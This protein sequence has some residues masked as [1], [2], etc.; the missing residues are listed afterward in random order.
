[1]DFNTVSKEAAVPLL[2]PGWGECPEVTAPASLCQLGYQ[3][4]QDGVLKP[5]PWLFSSLFPP[6]PTTRGQASVLIESKRGHS[7]WNPDLLQNLKSSDF[8]GGAV[9]KNP[10]AKA[11]DTRDMGSIP[12]WGRSPGGGNGNPLQHSCLENSMDRG[13]WRATVHG[14]AK[15]LNRTSACMC[16]HAHIHTHTLE[17]SDLAAFQLPYRSSSI[18]EE[19][20]LSPRPLHHWAAWQVGR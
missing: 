7:I 2:A 18:T 5:S 6:L 20:L 1:M 12:G 13:A 11:G 19:S 8:L 15:E 3:A 9:I 16:V 4:L 10:P 14:V 17:S